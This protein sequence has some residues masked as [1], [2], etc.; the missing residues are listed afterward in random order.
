MALL[1]GSNAI[2]NKTQDLPGNKTSKVDL[3]RYNN[4]FSH[5]TAQ[6]GNRRFLTTEAKVRTQASPRGEQNGSVTGFTCQRH[7]TMFNAHSSMYH[8]RYIN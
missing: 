4:L 6:A 3:S 1:L 8:T 2:R 7:S 5:A